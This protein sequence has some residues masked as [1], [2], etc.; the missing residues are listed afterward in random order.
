MLSAS[1]MKRLAHRCV[2]VFGDAILDTFI[3]GECSKLCRE[4]PVPVIV[5]RDEY[6]YPGGAANVAANLAAMGADVHF[7]SVV[8]RDRAGDRLMHAL[9][10]AGVDAAGVVRTD[11]PTVHKAR[12]LAG[13]EYVARVDEGLGIAVTGGTQR[14]LARELKRSLAQC[15]A[16]VVSDYGLGSFD[17]VTAE[18]IWEIEAHRPVPVVV[19]SH[20]VTAAVSLPTTVVTPNLEEACEVTGN[21]V[22]ALAAPHEFEELARSVRG[23]VASE[24]V[25]ITLGGVGV[26]IADGEGS[27]FIPAP[28]VEVRHTVGAGDSFTAAISLGLAAG[29]NLVDAASLGVLAG[30]VAVTKAHTATVTMPELG[31]VLR[32]AS[33]FDPFQSSRRVSR[34]LS[35][36]G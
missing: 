35:R 9:E 8:G 25:A 33:R 36:S 20:A 27:A 2:T 32:S 22:R 12:M 4:A 10:E 26:A 17:D 1:M 11:G 3:V 5:K 19:D 30:S 28:L 13:D 24:A 34:S 16:V 6:D 31:D 15:E 29:W 14:R 23:V 7:V 21:A 18:P